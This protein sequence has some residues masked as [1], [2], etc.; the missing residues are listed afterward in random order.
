MTGDQPGTDNYEGQIFDA[1]V[2]VRA[3]NRVVQVPSIVTYSL[4]L[5][6][7]SRV[8]SHHVIIS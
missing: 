4:S 6:R 3:S 8:I 1:A 7:E 2:W 5:E